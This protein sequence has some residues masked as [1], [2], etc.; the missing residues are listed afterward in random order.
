MAPFRRCQEADFGGLHVEYVGN[1]SLALVYVEL[2]FSWSVCVA[3]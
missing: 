3:V 2:G 1:T